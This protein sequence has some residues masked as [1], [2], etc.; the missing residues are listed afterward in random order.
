MRAW[1][2]AFFTMLSTVQAVDV[3]TVSYAGKKFTVCRVNLKSDKLQL[4]LKDDSGQPLK[5]FE[6]L[7][8]SL[9]LKQEKLVFA[10]NG[11]MYHGDM[12]PVGLCVSEGKELSPLNLA[13]AEGNFFLKPNGVFL[14]SDQGAKVI[15]SE[16]YPALKEKVILAT[17][18]G[19]MLL[20]R[21]RMHPAFREGSKNVLHRNA[22]GVASRNEVV[23][24]ITEEPVNFYEL[25]TLFRDVLKCPDA[26]F[27]DG[28]VS[29]LF[30]EALKR[31][32]KKMD[33]GPMLGVAL[34]Q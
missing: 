18:S 32:D 17:Q 21:G 15:I 27:L 30:A 23:F 26:L 11:G 28:T 24:A 12:S 31:S 6:R 19:P 25:A 8:Q 3:S 33:L 4:F 22:V 1:L 10:M 34:P 13:T 14:I 9:A 7:Q 5:S 20:S 29:S 16:E 2:L